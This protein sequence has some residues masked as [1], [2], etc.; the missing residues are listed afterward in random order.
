MRLMR[1]EGRRGDAMRDAR[2][3]RDHAAKALLLPRRRAAAKLRWAALLFA[4]ST[5]GG[6]GRQLL[7]QRTPLHRVS[8]RLQARVAAAKAGRSVT[9]E[10]VL[11]SWCSHSQHI[12]DD[13]DKVYRVT[14]LGGS[15]VKT[16]CHYCVVVEWQRADSEWFQER[17]REYFGDAA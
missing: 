6:V 13:G 1:G 10:D 12:A 15:V 14:G 16:I 9:L 7:P 8:A 5:V 17:L 3:S 11:A 4:L 2:L